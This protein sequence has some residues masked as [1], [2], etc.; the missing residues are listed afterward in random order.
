MAAKWSKVGYVDPINA[1]CVTSDAFTEH[2]QEE[3][4]RGKPTLI[5][6]SAHARRRGWLAI[7]KFDTSK[8]HRIL[9][10]SINVPA[11]NCHLK[12]TDRQTELP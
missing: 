1:L 11:N 6:F 8:I 5:S 3:S 9:N 7:A 10:L 12:V 4:G 2:K